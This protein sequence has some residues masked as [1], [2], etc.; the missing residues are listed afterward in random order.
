MCSGQPE[1]SSFSYDIEQNSIHFENTQTNN[2][3]FEV[4]FYI[5]VLT[6]PPTS[7]VRITC[8]NLV[9]H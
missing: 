4:C 5:H 7:G 9:L 1:S 8:T 6:L 3:I 2:N